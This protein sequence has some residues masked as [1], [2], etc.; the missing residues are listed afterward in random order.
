[1]SDNGNRQGMGPGRRTKV[2]SAWQVGDMLNRYCH[3]INLDK[4]LLRRG[5]EARLGGSGA[6]SRL[7]E[8]HPHLLATSPIFVSRDQVDQMTEIIDSIESTVSLKTYQDVALEWAPEVGRMHHGPRGVFFGYDFHLTNDGP[9]LIEVNTNAGGALLILHLAAAQQ[10]C[11]PEV[12]DFVVGSANLQ[13]LEQELVT[14]FR[15]ELRLQF[16]EK[17]LRRVAVV[18]EDQN[19][20][21]LSPE[22]VLF[23]RLF[24]DQGIDAIILS[25]D[26]LVL[27]NGEL[28][29]DKRAIDL[30][31]NRLTDFY[32]QSPQCKIL[33]QAYRDAVVAL[34]PSPYA[35][36]LYANK[37][38][39]TVLSDPGLLIDLGVNA[40]V[41]DVL[42][43]GVPKTVLVSEDNAETLWKNRRGLFFKPTW[44]FGSKGTYRGAKLTR[45][46]WEAILGSD[47]VAQ[48]LVPPSERLLING[49]DQHTMK[50]DVRCYVYDGAI[51]L[52]G[53]RMYRGQT[54]NF[55]T[56]GGGL[57]AV[58]TTQTQLS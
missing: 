23:K 19:T 38:N 28:Y 46:K 26:E 12:E 34:T 1:M 37:R 53:A 32:L 25:P 20:Q 54:T 10:A 45:K 15:E 36:A 56:D 35:H 27:R 4:Q 21:F 40:R 51:Q 47:Y 42:A 14:M 44:G 41:A 2:E 7:V 13:T 8:T 55:R 52:L 43:A 39:L 6:Y 22:F 57:A 33:K 30:V 5:L 3:C 29:A 58:F 16:P 17:E 31:Y 18:D 24:E 49:G 50:L 48:E 9:K 11:C